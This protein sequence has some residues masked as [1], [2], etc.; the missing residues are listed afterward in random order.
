MEF[1]LFVASLFLVWAVVALWRAW[2]LREVE[3]L[4]RDEVDLRSR[5]LGLVGRP[6][7]LIR[8]RGGAVIPEEKKSA[9]QLYPNLRIQLGVYLLLVE[10]VYGRRPPYGTLILG[11]NSRYKIRNTFWLRRKVVRLAEKLRRQ[12]TQ[13]NKPA[14]VNATPGQ[15]RSCGFRGSCGQARL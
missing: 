7:R 14:R 11:D 3:V 15:C 6:D 10:E 13:I 1:I 5:R 12:R 2:Q 9:K 4:S 8:L